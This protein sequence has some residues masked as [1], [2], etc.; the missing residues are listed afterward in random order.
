MRQEARRTRL[1]EANPFVPGPLWIILLIGGV[2]VLVYMLLYAD[3][4]SRY[5]CRRSWSAR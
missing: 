3:S 4:G 2:L 1:A 5:R